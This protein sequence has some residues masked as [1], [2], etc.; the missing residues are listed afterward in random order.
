MRARDQGDTVQLSKIRIK[1]PLRA[2]LQRDAETRQVTMNAAI[3]DR[4]QR[5]FD[6]EKSLGGPRLLLIFRSLAATA[7]LLSDGEDWVGDYRLFNIITDAW[8]R[9]LEAFR[10]EEPAE[11]AELRSTIEQMPPKAMEGVELFLKLSF[12]NKGLPP[13]LRREIEAKI[14]TIQKGP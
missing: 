1:E 3:A 7:E 10:P 8:Q 4:L 5:S 9:D 2:A 13:D 12:F 6:E 11:I 14:A